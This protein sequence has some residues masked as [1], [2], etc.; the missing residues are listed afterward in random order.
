ME[1]LLI[2]CHII[3]RNAV[4]GI[5]NDEAVLRVIL[6]L[7]FVVNAAVMPEGQTVAVIVDDKALQELSG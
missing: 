7:V 3:E 5:G 2:L 1:I 4:E 6:G